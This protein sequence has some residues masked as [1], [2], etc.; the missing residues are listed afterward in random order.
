[1]QSRPESFMGAKMTKP[2]VMTEDDMKAHAQIKMR[3]AK[4][5]E[6]QLAKVREKQLKKFNQKKST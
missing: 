6:K 3:S 4:R 5:N 2:Y 1:M